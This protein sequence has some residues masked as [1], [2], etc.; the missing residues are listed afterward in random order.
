MPNLT[1]EPE[2]ASFGYYPILAWA[3]DSHSE[4]QP[5]D[6]KNPVNTGCDIRCIE[7]W[8]KELRMLNLWQ[9]CKP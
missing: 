1:R 2:P 5:R 4:S 7:G 3:K 9:E 6:M 8:T